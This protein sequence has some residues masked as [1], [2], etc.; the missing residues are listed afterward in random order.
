[1]IFFFLHLLNNGLL[2]LPPLVVRG[3]GDVVGLLLTNLLQIL[4]GLF[5]LH[6]DQLY[7]AVCL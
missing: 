6:D 4:L 1:M 5:L 7:M 3:L 2:P